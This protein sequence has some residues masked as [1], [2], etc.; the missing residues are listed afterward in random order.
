MA[1]ALIN[2]PKQSSWGTIELSLNYIFFQHLAIS[3]DEGDIFEDTGN[4][5]L[6]EER[7][8]DICI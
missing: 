5:G 3:S 8:R 1:T 4:S 7:G 2:L 6:A